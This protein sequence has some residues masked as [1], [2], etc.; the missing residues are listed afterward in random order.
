MVT[1]LPWQRKNAYFVNSL[2]WQPQY[3]ADIFNFCK[4]MSYIIFVLCN[5][6][7]HEEKFISLVKKSYFASKIGCAKVFCI[8]KRNMQFQMVAAQ[9]LKDK[10][11]QFSSELYT[12]VIYLSYLKFHNKKIIFDRVI[13]DFIDWCASGAYMHHRQ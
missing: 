2:L 8:V 11:S 1:M 9:G 13:E 4:N 7:K 5:H 6:M 3:A 12:N 10:F